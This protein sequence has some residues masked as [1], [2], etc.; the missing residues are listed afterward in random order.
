[1]LQPTCYSA[2]L[3]GLSYGSPLA[4]AILEPHL[5][6]EAHRF[7]HRGELRVAWVLYP[8]LAEVGHVR[9]AHNTTCGLIDLLAAPLA[10]IRTTI[11]LQEGLE[12]LSDVHMIY[13]TRCHAV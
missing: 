6:R 12:L 4:Q 8:A 5:R 11:G 7:C 13:D 9:A 1:M 3:F 2:H 10:P